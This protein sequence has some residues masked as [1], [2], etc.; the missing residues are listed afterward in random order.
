MIDSV[1]TAAAGVPETP[2]ASDPP[3]GL[4]TV[5]VPG[6]NGEGGTAGAPAVPVS[7]AR[8]VQPA[9]RLLVEPNGAYGYVYRLVDVATGRLLVELPR[10][11]LGELKSH[12]EYAA[13]ALLSRSV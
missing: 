9:T 12:P 2:V 7:P 3:A 5:P 6:A 8:E 4:S 10:E 1:S 13:G 11:R